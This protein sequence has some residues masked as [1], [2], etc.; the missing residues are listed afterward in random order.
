MI[1]DKNNLVSTSLVDPTKFAACCKGSLF[2]VGYRTGVSTSR[3]RLKST[4]NTRRTLWKER[5]QESQHSLPPLKAKGYH[6]EAEPHSPPRCKGGPHVTVCAPP[7]HIPLSR[8]LPRSSLRVAP[9]A[10]LGSSSSMLQL[11]TILTPAP[12]T[13]IFCF[14][15]LH[16]AV[17]QLSYKRI[18]ISQVSDNNA[19]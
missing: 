10:R 6:G 8:S 3:E 14:K 16:G 12:H 4:A 1:R 5:N 18:S 17:H 2:T 15:M 13:Q 19:T 9:A 11:S 7:A